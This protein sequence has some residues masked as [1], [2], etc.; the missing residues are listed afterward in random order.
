MIDLRHE[1]WKSQHLIE[2]DSEL[3][4]PG[5]YEE[6]RTLA[7]VMIVLAIIGIATMMAGQSYRAAVAHASGQSVIAEL[8][9]ELRFARQL[10]IA[11]RE[12]VRLIFDTQARSVYFQRADGARIPHEYSYARTGVLIEEISA[13]PEISFHPSGRSASATTIRLRDANGVQASLTVSLTGRIS[14]S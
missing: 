11:K 13:G 3:T 1:S 4:M 2:E 9:S 8:S 14:L 12:R 5:R 10:A 6:G 7:E